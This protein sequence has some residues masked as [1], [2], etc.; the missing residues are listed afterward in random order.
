MPTGIGR[1]LHTEIIIT[2]WKWK[3]V[4]LE[5]HW[6]SMLPNPSRHFASHCENNNRQ[7]Y[8]DCMQTS[9]IDSLVL[10]DKLRGSWPSQTNFQHINN[11]QW[12]SYYDLRIEFSFP[13][14]RSW[15]RSAELYGG[16]QAHLMQ[17]VIPSI[18]LILKSLTHSG[19]PLGLPLG[20][21]CKNR[22]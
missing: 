21:H 7:W 9:W 1:Y 3:W 2:Q 17:L 13:H 16:G 14:R 8:H 6:T 15:F 18:Q 12:M 20:V 22:T 11:D 19:H 10:N 4:T 5:V